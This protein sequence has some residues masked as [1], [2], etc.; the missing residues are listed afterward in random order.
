MQNWPM[1]PKWPTVPMTPPLA[2]DM[3]LPP[4][5]GARCYGDTRIMEDGQIIER[6]AAIAHATRLKVFRLLAQAGPEGLASG[7]IA[8][9]LPIPVNTMST[10]LAML[11]R[12]GLIAPRRD[13][14]L[15]FS[16]LAPEAARGL[17]DALVSDCRDGRPELCAPVMAAPKKGCAPRSKTPRR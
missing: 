3:S 11:A 1:P 17:F 8:R 7:E 10:H 16:A 6:L 9:R 4:L 14:R 12:S 13:N 2:Q 5:D 15:I